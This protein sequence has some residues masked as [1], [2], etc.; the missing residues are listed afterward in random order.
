MVVALVLIAWIGPYAARSRATGLDPEDRAWFYLFVPAL[1]LL[2][3]VY[4]TAPVFLDAR[5]LERMPRWI[6]RVLTI[7]AQGAWPSDEPHAGPVTTLL[8]A[9]YWGYFGG[10]LAFMGVTIQ[11]LLTTWLIVRPELYSPLEQVVVAV[12]SIA[13]AA[14]LFFLTRAMLGARRHGEEANG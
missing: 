7:P 8:Q 14:W 13:A 2:V 5:A 6:A 1:Q 11:V 12:E 3:L 10:L 4:S 9:I